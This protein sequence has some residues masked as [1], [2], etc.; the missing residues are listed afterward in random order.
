MLKGKQKGGGGDMIHL[1]TACGLV[2]GRQASSPGNI[3]G[4][5][6]VQQQAHYPHVTLGGSSGEHGTWVID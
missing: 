3:H 5:S 2:K 6:P 4:R 1:P